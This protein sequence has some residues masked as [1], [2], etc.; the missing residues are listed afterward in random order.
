[1]AMLSRR[2]YVFLNRET[3]KPHSQR[4]PSSQQRELQRPQAFQLMNRGL[5]I[6]T[7]LRCVAGSRVALISTSVIT[8]SVK[9]LFYKHICYLDIF[10]G[11]FIHLY[12][13]M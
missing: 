1:M 12:D 3:S 13:V 5:L 11:T 2:R 4:A 10:L 7:V 9:H 6:V 8:N